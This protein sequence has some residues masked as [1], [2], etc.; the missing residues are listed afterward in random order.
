MTIVAAATANGASTRARQT[1]I[2][3]SEVA[4][5]ADDVPSGGPIDPLSSTLAVP[6]EGTAV[7]PI[8]Q[9]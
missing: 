8:A 2:A 7:V 1:I 4:G 5:V 3:R 9:R 6:S